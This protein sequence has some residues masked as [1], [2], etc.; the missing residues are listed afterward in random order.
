MLG[1]HLSDNNLFV[2]AGD[3]NKVLDCFGISAT[4]HEKKFPDFE[5]NRQTKEPQKMK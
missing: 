2:D 4:V 3:K 5:N 1:V